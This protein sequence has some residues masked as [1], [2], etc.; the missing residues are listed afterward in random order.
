MILAAL[1]A[2]SS[3]RSTSRDGDRY[4]TVRRTSTPATDDA[5]TCS[6]LKF[7]R[8]TTGSPCDPL[9]AQAHVASAW[10]NAGSQ[11]DELV[12]AGKGPV[13]GAFLSSGGRI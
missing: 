11:S 5:R 1:I 12:L 10:R 9:S 3:S 13:S 6:T 8:I 4:L 2:A 7:V